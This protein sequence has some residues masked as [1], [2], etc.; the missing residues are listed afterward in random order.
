MRVFSQLLVWVVGVRLHDIFSQ[1]LILF[2]ECFE[3]L[4][5]RVVALGNHSYTSAGV[6]HAV[7]YADLT[8]RD[9]LTIL[10]VDLHVG[11]M[12]SENKIRYLLRAAKFVFSSLVSFCV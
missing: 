6:F 4:P 7:T 5:A 10:I 11:P 12:R 2:T 3:T 1:H 8:K 9:E